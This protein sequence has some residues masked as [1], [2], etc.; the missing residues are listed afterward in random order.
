MIS[1]W[2]TTLYWNPELDNKVNTESELNAS[3]WTYFISDNLLPERTQG[4]AYGV[5]PKIHPVLDVGAYHGS[6]SIRNR[7]ISEGV[8]TVYVSQQESVDL[9]IIKD[10]YIQ[11]K[12][13]HISE[14]NEDLIEQYLNNGTTVILWP[15]TY[16]SKRPIRIN[17][18]FAKLITYGC[19]VIQ[20]RSSNHHLGKVFH[21]AANGFWLEGGTYI[22]ETGII[23]GNDVTPPIHNATIKNLNIVLGELGWWHGRGTLVEG[24]T[25]DGGGINFA[26]SNMMIRFNTF[27]QS[28]RTYRNGIHTYGITGTII[29]NNVFENCLRAIVFQNPFNPNI[30]NLIIG[31]DIFETRHVYNAGEAILFEGNT[32]ESNNIDQ[33]N[34][35]IGNNINQ[36]NSLQAGGRHQHNQ[37]IANKLIGTDI[38]IYNTNGDD[39][40]HIFGNKFLRNEMYGGLILD[41]GFN[42]WKETMLVKPSPIG[43]HL[44][45]D[46]VQ[47]TIDAFQPVRWNEINNNSSNVIIQPNLLEITSN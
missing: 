9:K 10:P 2:R 21:L 1:T 36:G 43:T 22:S 30:Q 41:H 29:A 8:H 37:Y 42:S 25:F 32:V 15:G 11:K 20:D 18:R 45:N 28:Y 12:K 16:Y 26:Q 5:T 33:H 3:D 47:T 31:N 4:L 27:K 17:E 38:R 46:R 39:S 14:W 35:I 44:Y 7:N 24:C 34:L 13:I 23:R 40:E 6:Y 19:T